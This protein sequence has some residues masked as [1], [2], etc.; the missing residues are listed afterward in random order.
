MIRA[1]SQHGRRGFGAAQSWSRWSPAALLAICLS[2]TPIAAA[3]FSLA[4]GQKVIG[5]VRGYVVQPG[6]GLNEVARKFDLGYTAL[7]AANP[8]VDQFNP[9]VGRRLMIPALYILPDAP[10]QGIVINLAQYRLFYFPPGGNRVETYPVGLAVFGS[11]TPLGASSVVRKEPNPTWYPPASIRAERPELPAMIPPGPD[12]PL[13]DYALHLGWPRYLIHGTNKPDGTGRN[14]S[15]GCIRM[16]PEDIERLFNEVSVGT[17]VRTVSQPAG[18]GWSEDGGLYVKVF[19]SKQQVEEIDVDHPVSYEPAAGVDSLVRA[20]ASSST[21]S[22]DWRV[23]QQAAQ[24]RTGMPLRVAEKGAAGVARNAVQPYD[25]YAAQPSYGQYPAQPSYNQ[26]AAQPSYSQYAAQ[27]PY[28][29]YAA[30]PAYDPNA[31]RP[32]YDRDAAGS[33]PPYPAGRPVPA[34]SAYRTYYDR[35]AAPPY[36]GYDRQAEQWAPPGPADEPPAAA[37]SSARKR[38]DRPRQ[39]AETLTPPQGYYEGPSSPG[40]YPWSSPR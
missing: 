28:Y 26:Y 5:E 6:E 2:A 13:G 9:G 40:P 3:E 10:R 31:A 12:N 27:P 29:G 24:E 25:Q 4:P 16:Y 8:G 7:A 22:V 37:R 30:Q 19:P 11:K 18:A 20:A 38:S 34:S 33:R 36:Y 32:P 14:V 39:E 1:L 23:V 15:H 35:E 17:Q 21:D